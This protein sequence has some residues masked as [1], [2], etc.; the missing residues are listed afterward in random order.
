MEP[1]PIGEV[2]LAHCLRVREAWKL[3]VVFF[4]AGF[5]TSHAQT[6]AHEVTPAATPSEQMRAGLKALMLHYDR[7]KGL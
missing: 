6:G 7:S 3:L 2:K 1:L 5:A 4:L